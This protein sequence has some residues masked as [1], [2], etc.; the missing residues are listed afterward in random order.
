MS[1]RNGLGGR[2]GLGAD[3]AQCMQGVAQW[4]IRHTCLSSIFFSDHSLVLRISSL[5]CPS[6]SSPSPLLP[7]STSPVLPFA[8][9]RTLPEKGGR[10]LRA[11]RSSGRGE[12]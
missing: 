3:S 4:Q 12:G 2:Q 7:V 6:H 5:S 8:G 9:I 10:T 11:T 1:A